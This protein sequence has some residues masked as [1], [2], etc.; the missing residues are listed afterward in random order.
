M[1]PGFSTH[2]TNS[3]AASEEWSCRH[4]GHIG[5]VAPLRH[6]DHRGHDR[7]HR[8]ER[9]HASRRRPCRSPRSRAHFPEEPSWPWRHACGDARGPSSAAARPAPSHPCPSLRRRTSSAAPWKSWGEG[10]QGKERG[11]WR[12]LED[13]LGASS[14]GLIYRVRKANHRLVMAMMAASP[15]L[16]SR[17][18]TRLPRLRGEWSRHVPSNRH[19]PAWPAVFG[20]RGASSSPRLRPEANSAR[21]LGPGATVGVLGTRV[22]RLACLRPTSRSWYGP[23]GPS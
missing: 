8:E 16:G 9:L 18:I 12:W 20:A 3:E 4:G 15:A 2:I 13:G 22:P 11:W 6:L 19:A 1:L 5:A 17:L 14:P 10:E 7:P 21:A 23:V